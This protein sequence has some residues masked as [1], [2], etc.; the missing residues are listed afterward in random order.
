M[1]LLFICTHNRCRSILAEA[2]TNYFGKGQVIAKSAGSHPAGEVHPLSLTYLQKMGIPTEGL[3]SQSWDEHEAWQA[4]VVITVCDSAANE[5]CP[6][7]FGQSL[8]VHWGL[9]DPSKLDGTEEEIEQ[10]FTKTIQTLTRRIETLLKRNIQNENLQ[11]WPDILKAL[12][13]A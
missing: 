4:D 13:S 2:V 1:K 3:C 10:A 6:L 7:W 12:E 8:R 5:V 11:A 9:S